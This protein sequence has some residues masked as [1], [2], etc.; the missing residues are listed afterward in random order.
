MIN[1]ALIGELLLHPTKRK[2]L[3]VLV[4]RDPAALS[5]SNLADILGEPLSNISYH[6]SEMAGMRAESR[7]AD[8]PLLEL[9]DTKQRR[10]ALEHFYRLAPRA[11]VS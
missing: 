10:G 6:V 5:P 4:A 2:I 3:G 7:F 9:C 1:Y 8:A 11:V